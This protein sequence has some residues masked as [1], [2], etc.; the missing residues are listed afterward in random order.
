[1]NAFCHGPLKIRGNAISE[2]E[3]RLKEIERE[4]RQAIRDYQKFGSEA[5][6]LIRIADLSAKYIHDRGSS[7]RLAVILNEEYA[8]VNR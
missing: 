5:E 1:M 8:K 7:L 6:Q 4:L 2:V 3:E